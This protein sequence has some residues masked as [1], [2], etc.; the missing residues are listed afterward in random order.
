MRESGEEDA[1]FG[2][3]GGEDGIG[4]A[5][6]SGQADGIMTRFYTSTDTS[7]TTGFGF[8][9]ATFRFTWRVAAFRQP[10][11]PTIC[12]HALFGLGCDVPWDAVKKAYR[13]LAKIAHPDLAPPERKQE[14]GGWM[15]VVNRLYEALERSQ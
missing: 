14:L 15:T 9:G 7:S 8:Q 5:V 3:G 1:V 4:R 13:R 11:A 10:P 6:L 2:F 12:A